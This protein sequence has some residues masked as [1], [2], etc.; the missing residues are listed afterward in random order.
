MMIYRALYDF[1]SEH[2]NI[3]SFKCSDLFVQIHK[4][5][6]CDGD[7]ESNHKG[8]IYVANS[9]LK[10]GYIPHTYVALC[11][12][13]DEEAAAF[14][15]NL[16][17]KCE[18]G[19]QSASSEREIKRCEKLLRQLEECA[20]SVEVLK[21]ELPTDPN[22]N[23][24]D[25]GQQQQENES[26]YGQQQQENDVEQQRDRI[27]N[28]EVVMSSGTPVSNQATPDISIIP[29]D[30]PQLASAADVVMAE[31]FGCDLLEHVKHHT[32]LGYKQVR[33][34][35]E[36]TLE[37]LS[38][39]IPQFKP[40]SEAIM[41][42]I[43]GSS[44]SGEALENIHDWQRLGC[45]FS[46]ILEVKTDVEQLNWA[47]Y[48]D[49]HIISEFLQELISIL[50]DGDPVV[51]RL[52]L[53]KDRYNNVEALV[54]YFQMETRV[55]ICQLLLKV[56]VALF[57]L[58]RQCITV[59]VNTDLPLLLARDIV[60]SKDDVQKFIH[61]CNVLT[62]LFWTGEKMPVNHYEKFNVEF[63]NY[64][65]ET[66]DELT[67]S[68]ETENITNSVTQLILAFNLQYVDL[69]A[70]TIVETLKSRNT[71]KEFLEKLIILANRED[72]P[73]GALFDHSD[74]PPNS[75]HK[76]LLDVFSQ[77]ETSDLF[78]TNDLKVLI[79]IIARKL[80]DLPSDDE[81]QFVYL[82]LAQKLM[83][84]TDYLDHRHCLDEF[85]E[86]FQ[87]ILHEDSGS[88]DESK[89]IVQDII[90]RFPQLFD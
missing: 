86:C 44:P 85:S 61:C 48:E 17:A 27:E 41:L 33:Q 18:V 22:E 71:A 80:V 24:S 55:T 73:V 72:D 47:L 29:K 39:N 34:A 14:K 12:D 8:W 60:A 31:L 9:S 50:I 6:K 32:G 49:Q 87:K 42:S 43:K 90:D 4:D 35:V 81:A 89:V 23:E 52:F 74:P 82:R 15:K 68:D 40:T 75:V 13:N 53:Q 2:K 57:S 1:S 19:K 25:Y 76:M 37:F 69:S 58:D 30:G 66:M 28:G 38:Q 70:N 10:H 78:Y 56:F 79:E 3:L 46:T 77:R 62:M 83:Y 88:P 45:I 67:T 36:S 64:L 51:C 11:Q 84:N 7:Q 63:V 5:A 59:L 54:Q 20:T 65:L 21:N 26:D 16:I